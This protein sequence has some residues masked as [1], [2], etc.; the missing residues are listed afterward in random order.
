MFIFHNIVSFTFHSNTFYNIVCILEKKFSSAV[1]KNMTNGGFV[2]QDDVD[3]VQKSVADLEIYDLVLQV[4][5]ATIVCL[6]L[7]AWS[8][9][10]GRKPILVALCIMACFK[11]LIYTINYTLFYEM[12][13]YHLLWVSA[14]GLSMDTSRLV[15]KIPLFGYIGNH[16]LRI[17]KSFN[18]LFFI[19]YN[20]FDLSS[21]M[22][23]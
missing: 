9:I 10:H 19:V 5:P 8:D 6:F 20:P 2:D 23:R 22:F 7:G 18:I 17:I 21:F 16:H 4:L 13:I 1:C 15:V 3:N 12:N 14:L 11:S